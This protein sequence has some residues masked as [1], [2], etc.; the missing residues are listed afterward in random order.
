MEAS[1]CCEGGAGRGG[2]IVTTVFLVTRIVF[3]CFNSLSRQGHNHQARFLCT[4]L[5][6]CLIFA[7]AGCNLIWISQI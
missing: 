5:Q 7:V 6:I 4:M 2:S 3:C 1:E